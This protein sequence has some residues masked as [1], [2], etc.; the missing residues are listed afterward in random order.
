MKQVSLLKKI[1][2]TGAGGPA[3]INFSRSLRIISE[4]IFLIGT[5]ANKYFV[6]L[7]NADKTF[8]VPKAT[9]KKYIETH[10]QKIYSLRDIENQLKNLNFNILAVMDEFSFKKRSEESDRIHFVV[11]K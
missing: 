1:L 2:C 9:E 4:K 7:A 11:Q 3:G 10:F 8:L 6:K 5:E